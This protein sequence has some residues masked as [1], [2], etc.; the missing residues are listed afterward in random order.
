MTKAE[1]IT[2][3]N[4]NGI[5]VDTSATKAVILDTIKSNN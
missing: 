3:A 1:L 2:Y 5:E 4:K